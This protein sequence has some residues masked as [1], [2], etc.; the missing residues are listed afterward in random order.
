MQRLH[1][2][3]VDAIQYDCLVAEE[4]HLR[5]NDWVIFTV[6][7]HEYC[8]RVTRVAPAGDEADGDLPGVRRSANLADQQRNQ[9]NCRRAR[10]LQQTAWQLVQQH[11]L[12]MHLVDS[13]LT[14]DRRKILFLFT[15]PGRVDFRALLQDLRRAMRYRIELRQ[16]GPRDQ[17][18]AVGGLGD[19]GR[20]L[21]CSSFLTNFVSINVKMAKTQGLTMNPSNVIGACGRLK[22]C[23]EF[24]YDGYR[25]LRRAMPRPG[26][27]CCYGEDEGRVVESNPLTQMLKL[28]LNHGERF[29]TV[30]ADMVRPLRTGD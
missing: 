25:A 21:C 23:L 5:K 24:E 26:S 22:C 11:D 30:P 2:R 3:V 6:D 27:R 19:C 8:G 29:V 15:A 13:H 17:A 1:V 14:F 9:E 12:P 10:E 7:R 20:K 16:I 18:A 4:L 28:S